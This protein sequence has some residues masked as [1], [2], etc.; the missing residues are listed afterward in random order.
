MNYSIVTSIS[1]NYL[2]VNKFLQ[3]PINIKM[4]KSFKSILTERA[5]VFGIIASDYTL[6]D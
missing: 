5:E 2:L 3:L 4:R 1:E 6:Y